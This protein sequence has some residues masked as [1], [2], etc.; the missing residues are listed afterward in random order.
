MPLLSSSATKLSSWGTHTSEG[1]TRNSAHWAANS[2]RSATNG[3]LA[4][5]VGVPAVVRRSGNGDVRAVL[6]LERDDAQQTGHEFQ[7]CDGPEGLSSCKCPRRNVPRQ[8]Q[9]EPP[10][11]RHRS[12]FDAPPAADPHA[13]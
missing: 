12:A 8:L 1:N 7:A 4:D 11:F 10:G 5:D 2:M 6:W 3:N 9:R 13:L